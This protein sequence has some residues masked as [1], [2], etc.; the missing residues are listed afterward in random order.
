MYMRVY[1]KFQTGYAGINSAH[2]GLRITGKYKGP[3]IRPDG[4]GVSNGFLVNIENST[5][6]SEG[7]PG[8]T[9][10]YV[11]QPENTDVYGENWYPDGT[12]TN[13]SFSFGPFFVAQAKSHSDQRRMDML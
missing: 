4:Q 9:H 10:A 11:Y 3:G 5:Q 1:T 12:V 2:N 8:R 7:E 13:G 6:Q